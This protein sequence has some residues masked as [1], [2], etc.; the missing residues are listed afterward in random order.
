MPTAYQLP[1]GSWRCQIQIKGK[2]LQFV[3]PTQ[4]EAEALASAA[5]LRPEPSSLVHGTFGAAVRDYLQDKS[6]VLSPSTLC[7]YKSMAENLLSPLYEIRLSR[8]TAGDI[9]RRVNQIAASHTPKTTRNALGLITA[10]INYSRPDFRPT[11]KL[12]QPVRKEMTIPSSDQI[13]QLLAESSADLRTA[14]YIAALCGLR[15][16]EISALEWKD[17]DPDARTISVSKSM[18]YTGTADEPFKI[19]Q[20]KSS[21]GYRT[22]TVPQPLADYLAT[23]PHDH[24]RIIAMTP[25][26]I[27]S[28]F[29][30]LRRRLGFSFRFHDLRH[31][32]ASFLLSLNVPTKYAQARLGHS[33]DYT[34][35]RVYQHLMAD[36]DAQ[37]DADINAA[38]SNIL[39]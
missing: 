33:T 3:A 12:P 36:K 32:Y 20:P 21:A 5:Y 17:Y 22:V 26:A 2:R 7:A 1:S 35:K 4:K 25:P 28:A 16:G 19:K 24:A 6:H 9:Q 30:Q 11:V 29:R 39:K 8:L 13:P 34:T 15:E 10:V 38:F 18:V 14:I 27:S 37:I 31:Y 23:L